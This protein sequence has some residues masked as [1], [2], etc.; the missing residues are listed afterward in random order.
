[1]P[2]RLMLFI[3]IF[4]ILLTFIMLN[5]G[6]DSRCY[7]NFGFSKTKE[8]VPVFLTIF[9]SFFLGLLCALPLSLLKK[10]RIEKSEKP[11]KKVNTKPENIQ[12]ETP[13]HVEI[14]EKIR[15]E[16]IEAKERF[17]A[18]RRGK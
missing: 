10:K 17:L 13:V 3:L 1:M 8:P 18:K 11:S 7:I 16:A 14:D 12:S 5:L 4:G 6:E 2:W 15:Q 9:I